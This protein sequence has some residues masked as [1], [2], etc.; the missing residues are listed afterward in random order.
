MSSDD[1]YEELEN[2]F[3]KNIYIG[4]DSTS[5]E[6]ERNECLKTPKRKDVV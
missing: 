5:K 6:I 3:C 4:K 1:K 2:T